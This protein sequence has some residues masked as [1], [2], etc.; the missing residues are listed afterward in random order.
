[1]HIIVICFQIPEGEKI[2]IKMKCNLLNLLMYTMIQLIFINAA[3]QPLKHLDEH[4][5]NFKVIITFT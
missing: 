1:M 3:K 5:E 2:K 4:W